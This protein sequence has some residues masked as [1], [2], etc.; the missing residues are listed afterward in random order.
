V[1][2]SPVSVHLACA[3]LAIVTFGGCAIDKA[4]RLASKARAIL[5]CK[6]VLGSTGLEAQ[7]ITCLAAMDANPVNSA[8]PDFFRFLRLHNRD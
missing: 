5:R 7:G 1:C 2:C 8:S 3:L 6:A 4:D